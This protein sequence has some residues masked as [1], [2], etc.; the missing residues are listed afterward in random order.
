[1]NK[2]TKVV[3][4]VLAAVGVLSC[5]CLLGVMA[6]GAAG[7]AA[8]SGGARAGADLSDSDLPKPSFELQGAR[9]RWS[10]YSFQVPPGMTG[11]AY[12][13]GYG[14]TVGPCSITLLKLRPAEG[15]L[16]AQALSIM[17]DFL[18]DKVGSFRDEYG[19]DRP[20][21]FQQR[22]VSG[23]GWEYVEIP[24]TAMVGKDG[25]PM[26][27]SAQLLLAKVGDKV[28]PVIGL[29]AQSAGCLGG[30]RDTDFRWRSL[31]YSLEF[32]EQSAPSANPLG[33]Q[34]V[35]TWRI[36]GGNTLLEN[37]YQ[38]DGRYKHASAYQT[39]REISNTRVLET[40]HGVFG[41]GKWV[42]RGDR[43]T[44]VPDKEGSKASTAWLRIVSIPNSATKT[45]WLTRL[46]RLELSSEG[47]PYEVDQVRVEEGG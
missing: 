11:A 13:D 15:A 23:R 41:D 8:V 16:D 22:G 28:A 9:Q 20:L 25:M 27:G 39:A 42:V 3:L 34:V 1:M 26:E 19:H 33:Q 7:A 24:P 30:P 45:G 12:T 21:D 43:L 29:D 18:K 5:T 38:A 37:T 10:E 2:T 46:Y 40:T 31:F 47:K 36:G 4:I 32:P 14:L 44:E 35:G 17:K 6:L